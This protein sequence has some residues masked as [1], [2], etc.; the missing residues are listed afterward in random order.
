M[1][2]NKRGAERGGEG[3]WGEGEEGGGGGMGEVYEG[4]RIFT[5][6]LRSFEIDIYSQS[7]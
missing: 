7:S 3:G 6:A 5:I 2:I 4:V 1:T